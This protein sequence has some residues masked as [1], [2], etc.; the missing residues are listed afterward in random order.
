MTKDEVK[1]QLHSYIDLKEE[2]PQIEQELEN[3]N[4]LRSAGNM[5]GLPHGSGVSDPTSTAALQLK[6][7]E[8]QYFN[9]LAKIAEAKKT[10]EAMID[11]LD[12]V[13]RKVLRYRYI[14]GLKWEAVCVATHY[15]W[16][17]VH[18]IHA[19]ALDKLASA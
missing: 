19:R 4:L 7:L 10:I 2:Y 5:D 17:A 13:E 16:R 1:K 11:E 14:K 12:P 18:N 3:I 6:A 15:S 8:E 9:Q